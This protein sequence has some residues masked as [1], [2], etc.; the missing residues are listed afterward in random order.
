MTHL[1]VIPHGID[2][3]V[4]PIP[5]ETRRPSGLGMTL[6]LISRRFERGVKGESLLAGMLPLL[7]PSRVRFVFVGEGRSRELALAEAHGFEAEVYE[8][9][10]YALMGRVY[11]KL[12]ALLV[13]SDFEGG[14]ASVP[15]AL[16]SGVPVFA[17][18]VGMC[19]DV[20]RDGDNGILL[21]RDSK[22]DADR[23]SAL[24]DQDCR[25]LGRLQEG[26]FRSAAE[27]PDWAAVFDRHFALYARIAGA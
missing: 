24:L 23:I 4:F 16:G 20:V 6:G 15:E 18:P 10:P 3:G 8:R 13:L 11:A 7:D 21:T 1:E 9:L 14:P 26:A 25:E 19:P 17:T 5:T 27:T 22:R 2:R 12:D